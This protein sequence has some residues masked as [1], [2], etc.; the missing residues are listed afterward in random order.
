MEA[1]RRPTP[2]LRLVR[3]IERQSV[4]S[5]EA[6]KLLGLSRFRVVELIQLGELEGYGVKKDERTRWY[7]YLDALPCPRADVSSSVPP[8]VVAIR[9]LLAAVQATLR[10]ERARR[11]DAMQA[12]R[13]A[14]SR[15]T[16][17]Y[18]D[19]SDGAAED[20]QDNFAEATVTD[21]HKTNTADAEA[22]RHAS[23]LDAAL[24]QLSQLI[25]RGNGDYSNEN[26]TKRP[27]G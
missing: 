5:V 26:S 19:L 15:L 2:P 24:T 6:G 23:K 9:D 4:S 10:A 22:Q 3:D 14:V 16:Q 20:A 8:D 27:A 18:I 12:A 25:S 7:A 13:S 17:A 1:D 21:G 11:L